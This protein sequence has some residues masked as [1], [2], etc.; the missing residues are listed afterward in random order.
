M[1]TV[2]VGAGAMGA[3]FGYL[4][5]RAGANVSLID[6]DPAVVKAISGSGLRVEGISGTHTVPVDISAEPGPRSSPDLVLIFV[7]AHQTEA[8]AATVKS[9]LGPRT[10]AVTLQSG[11]GNDE[12]LGGALGSERIVVG[13]TSLGSSV[14]SPGRI[15][16]TSWG[17]TTLAAKERAGAGQAEAVASFLSRHGIKTDFAEDAKSLIWGR[18]LINVGLGPITALARVRNGRLLEIETAMALMRSAVAEA[19]EVMDK[20]GIE[21]PYR[22][23][24]KRVEEMAHRT[25]ENLS[26]MLQDLYRGRRTEVDYINGAVVRLADELGLDAPVNRTLTMLVK[27]AEK[28]S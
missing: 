20:A 18:V 21:L 14:L 23:P 13:A 22:D 6:R 16:H 11:I 27:T 7:K 9:L 12:I 1:Q 5:H 26:T 4:L 28:A 19:M 24:L 8:A 17:D 25:A 2:I 10:V 3:L 15:M